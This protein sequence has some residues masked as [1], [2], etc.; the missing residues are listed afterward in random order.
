[1][2]V[3]IKPIFIQTLTV[4]VADTMRLISFVF[5]MDICNNFSGKAATSV[6]ALAAGDMGSGDTSTKPLANNRF[7]LSFL[8]ETGP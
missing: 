2:Q 3:A 1:M 5:L 8:Q 6:S 7:C 4:L